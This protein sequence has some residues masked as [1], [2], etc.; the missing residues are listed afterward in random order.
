MQEAAATIKSKEL[1]AVTEAASKAETV[2]MGHI[3]VKGFFGVSIRLCV[4][5]GNDGR[6]PPIHVQLCQPICFHRTVCLY[7]SAGHCKARRVCSF[8]VVC[9]QAMQVA[10]EA[11]HKADLEEATQAASN[12]AAEEIEE[13]KK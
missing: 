2:R 6:E 12:K 3:N 5:A 13:L 4:S 9:K 1:S 10:L 11:R 8:R 7:I